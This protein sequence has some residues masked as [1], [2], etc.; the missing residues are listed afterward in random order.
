[1]RNKDRGAGRRLGVVH[2]MRLHCG[3]KW[4]LALLLLPCGAWAQPEDTTGPNVGEVFPRNASLKRGEVNV[5]SGPGTQ[6]PV[7]WIYWRSGYPVALLARF[8]NYLKIRDLE[9]EEGWVHQAMV[10]KQMTA[11]VGGNA[12]I[13]LFKAADSESRIRARLAP[14]VVVALTEPCGPLF[15]EVRVVP[16][17]EEGFVRPDALEMPVGL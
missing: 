16:S 3:M 8:D 10:G 5:R 13:P 11:M 7:L 12:P 2:K 6:Y 14:G 17:G 15:C 1:M 4:I 9:G